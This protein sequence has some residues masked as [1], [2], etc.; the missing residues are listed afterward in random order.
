MPTYLVGDASD[1]LRNISDETVDLIVSSPP[2]NIG[3]SYEKQSRLTLEEYLLWQTDVLKELART[4]KPTGSLCWQAGTYVNA[5]NLL[6]LD[7]PFYSII[8]SL[9]LQLRNRIV[10][11]FNFGLNSDR[12][13]SGRY[14]TVLW[15]TKSDRYK[16]NLDPVRIP[17]LYPGKRHSASHREK[18]G[19][20][21]GNP[22][23]KNPS[24]VWEFDAKK[25]FLENPIWDFPNVKNNHP[26]K[27]DHPCQF[28]IELAE[29]C[30][31]AFTDEND[32]VLDPFVGT[33]STAL[34]AQ[35]QKRRSIGID[36]EKSFVD[37]S[38]S[39]SEKI[40]DGT[41]RIRPIGKPI[42]RPSQSA[43]VARIPAEWKEIE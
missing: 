3:K 43:K 35:K 27:E 38:K 39:R 14:E 31:L 20:L 12:R 30:V 36:K 18:S 26:E 40:C 34:A 6:P 2:Y 33:G 9:G 4:L 19:K 28:P 22:K 21:S 7:I 13:F 10:W 42:A 11:R 8:N 25:D 15:F 5:G 17:Q 1:H 24:D 37:I 23:G 41:L 16:F 29:R 32:L